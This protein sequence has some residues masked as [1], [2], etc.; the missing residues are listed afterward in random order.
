MKLPSVIKEIL[1]TSG[2]L[3]V[4]GLGK[5]FTKHLP[6]EIDRSRNVLLPPGK[7]V[8]FD[9]ALII[10]DGKLSDYL[11]KKYT[12][13]EKVAAQII[14]GFVDSVKK[15][16]EEK[17][18]ATIE[19]IGILK[20]HENNISL[21]PDALED[22][23]NEV[24][25]S[26]EIPESIKKEPPAAERAIITTPPVK[27]AEPVKRSF[28]VWIPVTIIALVAALAAALY[29]T[30]IGKAILQDIAF[31]KKENIAESNNN[32]KIVFGKPPTETDSLQQDISRQ[33]DER[34]TKENA[35]S[36][37]QEGSEQSDIQ[38]PESLILENQSD[39]FSAGPYHVIA[40]SFHV[41]GNAERYKSKLEKQG[42]HPVIMPDINSFYM[43]SLGSY[44]SLEQAKVALTEFS[45][46]F[47]IQLWIKKI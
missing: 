24:L 21:Q 39:P 45:S 28:R 19:G 41:P 2:S 7:T 25:P 1:L 46:K 12:L 40:G 37:K 9:E 47:D 18:T 11:Q 4:P 13:N 22:L 15:E 32:N 17:K 29:F 26:I 20:V 34:T 36:Y 44:Q 33:L 10:D 27:T 6:A 16:L 31:N 35:L 43:V 8:V 38:P 42:F 3:V 5:F 14:V 23:M 30:G